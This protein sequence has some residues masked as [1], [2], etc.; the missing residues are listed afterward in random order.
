MDIVGALAQ[1]LSLGENAARGLAGQVLGL[2]EEHVREHVSFGAA[3]RFHDAIPEM[4]QWQLATPTLRPGTLSLATIA[5]P[6]PG[7]SEMELLLER[8][9]LELGD[10]PRVRAL[11]LEF[12]STR[13][14]PAL[15]DHVLKIAP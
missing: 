15:F 8:F 11:A 14:E 10:V 13:L 6:T 2:F 9:H 5:T 4:T 3:A 7:R 1:R 12:L